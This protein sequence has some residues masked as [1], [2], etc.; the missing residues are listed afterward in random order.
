MIYLTNHSLARTMNPASIACREERPVMV[1][2]TDCFGSYQCN[3][4]V[5]YVLLC[6]IPFQVLKQKQAY[7]GKMCPK[8]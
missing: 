2:K 5:T 8:G 1:S 4:F 6:I 3:K 7:W